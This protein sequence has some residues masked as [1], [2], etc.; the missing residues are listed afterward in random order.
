MLQKIDKKTTTLFAMSRASRVC[1]E[2]I[3]NADIH[4]DSWNNHKLL[5]VK[6]QNCYTLHLK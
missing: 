1:D 2:T 3:A 6:L 4:R 5:F